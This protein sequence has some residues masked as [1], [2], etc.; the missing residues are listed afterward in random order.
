MAQTSLDP[1]QGACQHLRERSKLMPS[2]K[3]PFPEKRFVRYECEIGQDLADLDEQ[4][5]EKCF[6][7][8]V[9][10]WMKSEQ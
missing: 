3:S 9:G 2:H 7:Q 10:C 1:V 6:C 5:L 8:K 4:Q